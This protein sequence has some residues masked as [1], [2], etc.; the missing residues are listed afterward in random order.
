MRVNEGI[1]IAPVAG[2]CFEDD[3]FQGAV[4]EAFKSGFG[5]VL[6]EI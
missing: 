5:K 1:N 4:I 2:V 3:W 6:D